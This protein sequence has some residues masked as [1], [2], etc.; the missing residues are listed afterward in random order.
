MSATCDTH[1]ST[2][3][4]INRRAIYLAIHDDAC[5]VIRVP[6]VNLQLKRCF[7]STNQLRSFTPYIW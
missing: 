4:P 3:Q 7:N 5:T 6:S 1:L 2:D